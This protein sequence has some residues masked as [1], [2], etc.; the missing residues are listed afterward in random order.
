MTIEFMRRILFAYFL[1][2]LVGIEREKLNRPAG[3][4]T[5]ILVCVGACMAMLIGIYTSNGAAIDYTRLPAQVISGIGFLGAGTIIKYGNNIKGLTT[6]ASLWVVA[7]FGL[8]AGAGMYEI[9]IFAGVLIFL[10]LVCIPYVESHI[11]K[12]KIMFN[13]AVKMSS[14]HNTVQ[15][16]TDL[17]NDLDVDIINIEINSDSDNN[18]FGTF[19]FR[20][21][22]LEDK[23]ILK[24]RIKNDE[25]IE[26]I[27]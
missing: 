9:C 25:D 8:A 4:R 24:N 5:H 3:L 6:A 27:R 21:T 12:K 16:I 20:A 10:T 23:A 7:C 19:S 15:M 26:V 18:K 1:G 17:T 2:A 13:I 22:T 11:L 14:V